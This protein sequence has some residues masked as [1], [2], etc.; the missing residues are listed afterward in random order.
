MLQ[1]IVVMKPRGCCWREM[2]RQD[3]SVH[4][5]QPKEARCVVIAFWSVAPLQHPASGEPGSSG[6]AWHGMD[7]DADAD[8]DNDG[9]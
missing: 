6:V 2:G 3:G 9:K 7:D 1:G 8:D 4:G 5:A